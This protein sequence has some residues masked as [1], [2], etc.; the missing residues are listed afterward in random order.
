MRDWRK[1]VGIQR[2]RNPEPLG[3]RIEVAVQWASPNASQSIVVDVRNAIGNPSG[4]VLRLTLILRD[5]PIVMVVAESLVA[6]C[7]EGVT[8]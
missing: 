1:S 7:P 5:E 6:V 2:G 3:R 4:P 8:T